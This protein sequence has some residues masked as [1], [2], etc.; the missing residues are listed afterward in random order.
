MKRPSFQ[1][2][3]GDWQRNVE[4]QSC[5]IGAR[6]LWIEMMCVMHQA[7]PYGHLLL[8][9]V[10]INLRRLAQ[11]VRAPEKDV[12]G[13]LEDLE[14]VGV[15]SR[16]EAG[17]I[18]SRRMVADETLREARAEGGKAGAEH[19]VK[20]REH[21]SKGGRPSEKTGDIKPPSHTEQGGL[22]R[23]VSEPRSNPP[24]SS[25]S[26]ASSS[27][28][29]AKQHARELEVVDNLD[30]GADALREP[31]DTGM[32][33]PPASIGDWANFFTRRGYDAGKVHTVRCRQAF[34]AWVDAK[35]PLAVMLEAMKIARAR[36]GEPPGSPVYFVGIINDLMTARAN[37]GATAREQRADAAKAQAKREL[38]GGA[39]A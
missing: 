11:L 5:S 37:G 30:A 15:F 3:P 12:A 20:G 36:R 26:S 27:S 19:G 14:E 31:P 18:F 6:G 35:V 8:N 21:G 13:W 17:I 23:G 32:P 24:P 29:E 4:L 7:E 33:D 22:S 39:N 25:S 16:T 38:F 10:P 9:G 28:A 1:F 2:Y 34:K